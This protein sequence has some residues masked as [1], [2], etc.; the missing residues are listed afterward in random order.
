M[1]LSKGKV[2]PWCGPCDLPCLLISVST[3]GLRVGVD[4]GQQPTEVTATEKVLEVFE[5]EVIRK[6]KKDLKKS[7]Q[8]AGKPAYIELVNFE[9]AD[10]AGKNVQRYGWPSQKNVIPEGSQDPTCWAEVWLPFLV[11]QQGASDDWTVTRPVTFGGVT[12]AMNSNKHSRLLVRADMVFDKTFDDWKDWPQH[13]RLFFHQKGDF[14][15]LP[16]RTRAHSI[17]CPLTHS[18][19]ATVRLNPPWTWSIT[20]GRG[21]ENRDSPPRQPFRGSYVNQRCAPSTSCPGST[22]FT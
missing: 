17:H 21:E 18:Q 5:K 19:T 3:P 9:I 1:P 14:P 8:H 15:V 20:K 16:T 11:V 7:L 22:A 10:G 4:D 13:C 6:A 12:K 2:P